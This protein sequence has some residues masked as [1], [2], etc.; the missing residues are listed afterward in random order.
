MTPSTKL[1]LTIVIVIFIGFG[2][3]GYYNYI[4]YKKQVLQH[5]KIMR[6][7]LILNDTLQSL[8]SQHCKP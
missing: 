6:D 1:C 8:I 5:E 3:A 4:D 2:S 7:K